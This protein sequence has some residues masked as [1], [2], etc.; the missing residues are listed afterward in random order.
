[1]ARR[2]PTPEPWGIEIYKRGEKEEPALS[3]LRTQCPD[4]TRGRLM[5]I[6]VAVSQFPPPSFPTS[7]QLWRLMHEDPDRGKVDM[8][9]ILEARVKGEGVLYRL[10]CI[11][12][13][14]GA[15]H[16]LGGP[17]LVLMGGGVKPERTAMPQAVYE[18]M[19]TSVDNYRARH[20]R[21]VLRPT[22]P[23]DR[24]WPRPQ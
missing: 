14:D 6:V 7:G 12:D 4:A 18:E 2:R 23:K 17:V 10:F 13:R 22:P 20:P 19:R 11:L 3:F 24:W 16:G 8:S 5:A 15:K 1:M 21:P 9:G